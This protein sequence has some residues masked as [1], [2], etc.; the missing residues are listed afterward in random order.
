METRWGAFITKGLMGAGTDFAT[1]FMS[2]I[3][4]PL[5]APELS[6]YN[7]DFDK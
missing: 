5:I 6:I 3:E 7:Y 4:I 1:G 2:R